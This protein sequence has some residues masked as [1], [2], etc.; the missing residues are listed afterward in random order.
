MITMAGISFRSIL[1]FGLFACLLSRLGA[2]SENPGF[3]PR[4]TTF[5]SFNG[6][7]VHM[8]VLPD[9]DLLA[10]GVFKYTHGFARIK[11]DGTVIVLTNL[12]ATT[13]QP[14]A[15]P[16]DIDPLG[17][18]I[19][20]SN[21]GAIQAGK[22]SV[23]RITP[24][25]QIDPTF[26]GP[27]LKQ[28][29][30]VRSLK[31]LPGGKILICGD[32]YTEN[33]TNYFL[34]LNRNGT[35]DENTPRWGIWAVV[36]VD[37]LGRFYGVYDGYLIRY[38][39][40]GS[41]DESFRG[42][43]FYTLSI[44]PFDPVVWRQP[45][46]L[47]KVETD[48]QGRIIVTGNF[49]SVNADSNYAAGLA[50]LLPDGSFDATFNPRLRYLEPRYGAS[51]TGSDFLMI[52]DG[53]FFTAGDYQRLAQ[54]PDGKVYISQYSINNLTF[55]RYLGTFDSNLP[56][57]SHVLPEGPNLNLYLAGGDRST[58]RVETSTSLFT[59]V[60]FVDLTNY[61]GYATIPLPSSKVTETQ[62]FRVMNR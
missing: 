51:P 31:L 55:H 54:A 39:P 50:R 58:V 20:A 8:R 57:R 12:I 43:R 29:S 44:I 46:T 27:G 26:I 47:R 2:A 30:D 16:F 32:L 40:D 53:E 59:W 33:S 22:L 11:P 52:N 15:G 4:D 13:F 14:S 37:S 34:R 38:L 41:M 24:D 19:L 18:I 48:S 25:G 10:S 5:Q 60:P 36:H 42:A 9:G 49:L 62:F 7:A 28:G 3:G 1:R 35:V 61:S 6:I 21:H 17:N 23:R 45:A 56:P